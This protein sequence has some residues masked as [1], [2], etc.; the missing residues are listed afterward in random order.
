VQQDDGRLR[1]VPGLAVEEPKARNVGGLE[2]HKVFSSV[3]DKEQLGVV[4]RFVLTPAD[5]D[6]YAIIAASG[7][8]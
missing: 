5:A 4:Q 2:V 6:V 1:R 3:G 7:A 8:I